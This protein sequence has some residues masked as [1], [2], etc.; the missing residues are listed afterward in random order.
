MTHRLIIG[1]HPLDGSYGLWLS[2][3]GVDAT[4]TVDPANFL[5]APGV[6]NDMVLM[7]GAAS[8]GQTVFFPETL[9]FVPTVVYATTTAFGIDYYPFDINFVT[10]EGGVTNVNV[11]TS[12]IAFTDFTNLGLKFNYIVTNRALV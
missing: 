7:A 8:G 11:T 4:L 6:K 5:I 2:K 1:R 12:Y 3:P 9:S 10:K